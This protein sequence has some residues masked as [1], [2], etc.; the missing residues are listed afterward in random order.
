MVIDEPLKPGEVAKVDD[1]DHADEYTVWPASDAAVELERE[2]WAIFAR[3]NERHETG[4]V[5]PETHPGQGDPAFLR[6]AGISLWFYSGVDSAECA[7]RAGQSIEVLFRHYAKFLDG[8]R[9]QANRLIE[10]SMNEWQ[11]V[12]HGEAPEG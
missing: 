11:R 4:T 12:S 2:R 8:L 1:Y 10:Q 9:E 5:G 7:R 3:W 6:H